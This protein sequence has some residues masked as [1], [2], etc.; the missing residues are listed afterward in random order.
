MNYAPIKQECGGKPIFGPYI[1]VQA[2]SSQDQLLWESSF[3]DALATFLVRVDALVCQL[4][5]E[6]LSLALALEPS[7]WCD[8]HS[9]L[10]LTAILE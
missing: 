3:L 9:T 4:T 10:T 6:S 8:H 1:L 2:P 5:P 7:K